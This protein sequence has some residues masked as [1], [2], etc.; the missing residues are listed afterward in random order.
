LRRRRGVR[1]IA[2]RKLSIARL[3]GKPRWSKIA[4]AVMK[5]KGMDLTDDF[6]RPR[7]QKTVWAVLERL[8]K[9]GRV[10]RGG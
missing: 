4:D 5:R 2:V 8:T 9:R 10:E 6:L 7:I 3:S 1:P